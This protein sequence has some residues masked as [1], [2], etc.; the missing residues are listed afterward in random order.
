M[1][2]YWNKKSIFYWEFIQHGLPIGR[3]ALNRIFAAPIQKCGYYMYML[4][5]CLLVI[6]F[7][8]TV[9][10]CVFVCW[11]GYKNVHVFV[12]HLSCKITYQLC[13]NVV[14][15]GITDISGWKGREISILN[16]YCGAICG[17]SKVLIY[18]IAMPNPFRNAKELQGSMKNHFTGLLGLKDNYYFTL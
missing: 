8:T 13:N 14:Q 7:S 5:T 11:L 2:A 12:D 16:F 1:V 17:I 18:W 9:K 4:G 6:L 15:F 10:N 3:S